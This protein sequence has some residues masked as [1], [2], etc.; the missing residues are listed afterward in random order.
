MEMNELLPSK[1]IQITTAN[2]PGDSNSGPYVQLFALCEDGSI[3][4]QYHSSGYSNVPTDGSW[5]LTG[6]TLQQDRDWAGI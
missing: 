1:P 6:R 4:M 2:H 3:W 5:H